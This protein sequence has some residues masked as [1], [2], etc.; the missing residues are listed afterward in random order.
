MTLQLTKDLVCGIG[1]ALDAATAHLA[2][3]LS[4]VRAHPIADRLP[5]IDPAIAGLSAPVAAREQDDR[6]DAGPR[7]HTPSQSEPG[8]VRQARHREGLRRRD[9][10]SPNQRLPQER[11][12][13]VGWAPRRRVALG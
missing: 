5:G 1:L 12:C 4:D 10:W 8:P 13:F 11:A 6:K 7:T 3:L 9:R 2:R